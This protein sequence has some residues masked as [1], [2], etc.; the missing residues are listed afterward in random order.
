MA[1]L[2]K[3]T[4]PS[5]LST[6]VMSSFCS[7]PAEGTL[8]SSSTTRRLLCHSSALGSLGSRLSHRIDV[9]AFSRRGSWE[10]TFD[11]PGTRFSRTLLSVAGGTLSHPCT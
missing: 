11:T 9:L 2:R 4:S 5:I 10:A 8:S 1:S 3:Q 7:F 6:A